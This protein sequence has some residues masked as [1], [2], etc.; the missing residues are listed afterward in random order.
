[1]PVVI[2]GL[3]IVAWLLLAGLP[4]GGAKKTEVVTA[5][6][7]TIAEGTAAAP[8]AE[9]GTVVEVGTAEEPPFVTQTAPPLATETMP[10]QTGSGPVERLP[11]VI[12][13]ER[14]VTPQPQPTPQPIPAT[15]RPVPRPL[16][17]TPAPRPEPQEPSDAPREEIS[18]GEATATLRNHLASSNPYDGV[19]SSCLQIRSVGYVN[20]GYTY[21][22]W[23]SCVDGGG[24]RMLGR[25][26]VDAKTREVFRQSDNGRYVRP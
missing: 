18:E 26:R 1:V 7:E 24:T 2:V 13:E 5:T 20:V 12:V 17:T 14:P 25:W 16:P 10:P 11:P 3:V 23:D 22:V 19:S 15:P 21:S 9:T 8:P 4:F 6:T